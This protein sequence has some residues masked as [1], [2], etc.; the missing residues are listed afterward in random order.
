MKRSFSNDGPGVSMDSPRQPA[1]RLSWQQAMDFCRWLSQRTGSRFSLPSEA[2]WEYACRAGTDSSMNYGSLEEDFSPFSNM[3]DAALQRIYTY[4][5]GLVVLQDF[6]V[7][8]Q[9][10]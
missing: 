6:P 8:D 10:R 5:G 2:Q 4:T 7:V 3:A 9:C 1:V